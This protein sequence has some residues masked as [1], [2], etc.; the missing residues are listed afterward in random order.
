MGSAQSTA[1]DIT[2]NSSA[3]D[4]RTARRPAADEEL[5]QL[6][7]EISPEGQLYYGPNFM[8]GPSLTTGSQR[9]PMPPSSMQFSGSNSSISMPA[10]GGNSYETLAQLDDGED[11][12]LEDLLKTLKYR[13]ELQAIRK[14]CD[15]G[16][17][18]IC[19]NYLLIV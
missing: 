3:A 2:D 6:V 7:E 13:Q 4:T 18:S 1:T 10:N 8:I 12:L 17:E 15:I 14:L 16:V 9:R 5:S 19:R 11:H